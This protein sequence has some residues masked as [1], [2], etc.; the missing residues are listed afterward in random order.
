VKNKVECHLKQ[1]GTKA[2]LVRFS[3]LKK[4]FWTRTVQL[5]ALP[6]LAR[7]HVQKNGPEVA[8]T[9]LNQAVG[10]TVYLIDER[11]TPSDR[12]V[13]RHGFIY[14]PG[15][16]AWA[17]QGPGCA[18]C[19][20]QGPIEKLVCKLPIMPLEFTALFQAGLATMRNVDVL[21]VF[22]AG[23]FLNPGEIPVKT[24]LAIARAVAL[25]SA[26]TLRVEARTQYVVPKTVEPLVREL[27]ACAQLDVA[28]GL[29]SQD[30][31]LRNVVLRKG[32]SRESFRHAVQ[33]LK[34]LGARASVYVML[35]PTDMEEGYAVQECLDTI[36]FAF[37]CGADEVLLQARYSQDPNVRCPKLW[38]IAKVLR[39]TAHLGPVTLGRWEG[40][41]PEPKVW[42]TNCPACTPEFMAHIERWR[43]GLSAA[44]VAEKNLP[45]CECRQAWEGS[46]AN[47]TPPPRKRRSLLLR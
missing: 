14:L 36:R 37:E 10:E 29:E 7:R 42:P 4:E 21:N 16:C 18:F 38:S 41:L 34:T 2:P 27:S 26:T 9:W 32:M 46:L 12:C 6:T 8:R 15:G 23:S 28:L 35:M 19:E 3:F 33:V 31:Y 13:R 25:S 24:Q 44:D 30:D 11:Y 1:R 40:E 5:L 47:T 45:E 20:F 39:E 43:M 22:T 17:V